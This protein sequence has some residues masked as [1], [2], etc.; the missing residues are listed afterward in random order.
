MSR[1]TGFSEKYFFEKKIWNM[2]KVWALGSDAI[3]VNFSKKLDST[4]CFM[5]V[6]ERLDF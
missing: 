3:A 6:L 1:F 5:W 4:D 2:N